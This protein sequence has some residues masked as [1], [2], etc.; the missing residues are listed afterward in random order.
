M[1]DKR[2]VRVQNEGKAAAGLHRPAVA[3]QRRGRASL[4]RGPA[5]RL[6]LERGLAAMSLWPVGSSAV[7]VAGTGTRRPD[8]PPTESSVRPSWRTET[9]CTV[10]S[11]G[12]AAGGVGGRFGVTRTTSG[13]DGQR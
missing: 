13:E 4:A 3:A 1:A 2:E 9:Q 12:G 5:G 7:A 8:Q 10:V 6:S 11:R